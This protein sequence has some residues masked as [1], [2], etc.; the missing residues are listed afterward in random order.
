MVKM[1]EKIH[2]K[3]KNNS[4]SI[5]RA[6]RPISY[7][8]WLLGVGVAH[9]QKCPKIITI[10]IRLIH[11]AVCSY[12][13][14]CQTLR[15]IKYF[16]NSDV[17][18]NYILTYRFHL[19]LDF[20][21]KMMCFISILYHIYHGLSQYNKWAKLM[22]RMKELDQKIRE[23]IS[24]HDQSIKIV[25]TLAVFI[26]FTYCPLM[27]IIQALYH[28]HIFLN[29]IDELDLLKMMFNYI[30]AQ[31][32]INSFAFDVV[33][34]V[35]YCRFQTVNKLIVQLDELS[36]VQ[37]I[38]FKIR[39]VRE[40]Y[41]DICDLAS[42]VNDIHGL[43][44]LFCAG[45]CFTMALTSLF[46]FFQDENISSRFYLI[47]HLLCI[48]Y[49]MQFYLICWIC[50]LACE[51]S[52][53]TKRNIHKIILNCKPVNLDTHEANN[54]SSIKVRSSVEDKIGEQNSNCSSSHYPY[55]V[56]NF[57]R[58]NLDQE[59]VIKE[60]NDFSI[61]LQQTRVAFTACD[62]FEVNNSSYGWVSI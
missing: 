32:L 47:E 23:E 21:N 31:L 45:N 61:Q 2:V 19:L 14:T 40:L 50:T 51:E 33:V 44:L 12:V 54:Q 60:I 56:E 55:V 17:D 6:L 36:D 37:W 16:Y 28:S 20:L 34:Y 35:L 10:I 24:M 11:M 59:C 7:I 53:R 25:E 52:K 57:L 48:V 5:E 3:V 8:S 1:K 49:S 15:F 62:F 9:P 46:S 41:T 38:A 58:R 4:P 43:H 18:K 42:M 30:L 22:D 13:A 29:P 26:T 39:R 27:P